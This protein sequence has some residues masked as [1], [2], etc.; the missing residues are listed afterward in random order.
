MKKYLAAVLAACFPH[1]Y[2]QAGIITYTLNGHVYYIQENGSAPPVDVTAKLNRTSTG[3][4]DSQLNVSPNGAWFVMRG[5]RLASECLDWDCLIVMNAKLSQAY[6][7]KAGGQ[8]AHP[9][10]FSAIS[11][12]GKTIVYPLGGGPSHQLDLWKITQNAQGVWSAP[13]VLTASLPAR[14][15]WNSQPAISSDG[16]KVLFDCGPQA[17]G[18]PGTAICE[19]GID[20]SGFRVVT[21][22]ANKP[23]NQADGSENHHADYADGGIVFEGDWS[24]ERLWRLTAGTAAASLAPQAVRYAL[25]NDN[26]PCVLRSGQIASLWL[27][28]TGNPNGY[29]EL[30]I[31]GPQ[32]YKMLVIGKDINDVGLGCGG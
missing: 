14:Y 23:P 17:Y 12:D 10:G 7:L 5:R 15:A 6:A 13:V 1:T 25:S 32:G 31:M 16:S 29:H 2:C 30:K 22:P 27:S 19:I 4:G 18:G 28:R 9:D 21:S 3:N 20:G 8:L 24:G 11:S 26:S